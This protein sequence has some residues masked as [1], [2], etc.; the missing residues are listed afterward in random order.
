[1]LFVI[2]ADSTY[3]L[4]NSSMHISMRRMPRA[5]ISLLKFLLPWMSFFFSGDAYTVSSLLYSNTCLLRKEPRTATSSVPNF[6]R[7]MWEDAMS[8]WRIFWLWIYSRPS[9]TVVKYVN[10]SSSDNGSFASFLFLRFALRSPISKY[11]MIDTSRPFLS[12]NFVFI[13]WTKGCVIVCRSLE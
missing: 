7:Y 10:I 11:S 5:Q 1:M 8:K 3:N 9:K 4:G 6:F 12:V 2:Y 13:V